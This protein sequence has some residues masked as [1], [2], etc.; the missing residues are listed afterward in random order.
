MQSLRVI[1]ALASIALAL[2]KPCVLESNTT[3]LVRLIEA[4]DELSLHELNG[5]DS[6]APGPYVAKF[7]RISHV[8]GLTMGGKTS[9][10]IIYPS[11]IDEDATDNS[12]FPLLSFAHATYIGG[13]FPTTDIR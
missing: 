4:A 1:F 8:P 11:V 7:D 6:M 12:T 2:A 5:T 13:M 9:A 10:V 3:R